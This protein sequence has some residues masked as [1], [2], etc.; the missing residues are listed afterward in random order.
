MLGDLRKRGVYLLEE[1]E[2][3]CCLVKRPAREDRLDP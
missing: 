3:T 2:L 1:K